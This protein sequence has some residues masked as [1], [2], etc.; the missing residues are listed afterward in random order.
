LTQ[1][2]GNELDLAG[3]HHVERLLGDR[4]AVGAGLA[5]G[6][7]PLVGEHRLDDD[8][9]AVAARHLQLVLVGLLQHAEGFEVGDDGLARVEAVEAAVLFRC[10]VVD[11]GVQRQDR[12]HRQAVALAD[13]VVVEVVRRRDLDA[14]GAE[15]EVDVASA[16]IGISRSVSGSF[17]ILPI[18]CL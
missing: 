16:M 15:F 3:S 4:L 6:D 1:F 12:D 2:S 10:V 9:G 14:A 8:A 17:T 18:R 7:E 13:R 5:H 11:L